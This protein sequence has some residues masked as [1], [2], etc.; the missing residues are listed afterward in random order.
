VNIKFCI[1]RIAFGYEREDITE[2]YGMY[3]TQDVIYFLFWKIEFN[4]K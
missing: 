2:P 3:H 4:Y 1:T